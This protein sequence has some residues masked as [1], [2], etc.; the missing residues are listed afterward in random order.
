M[1]MGRKEDIFKKSNKLLKTSPEMKEKKKVKNE[2]EES[3]ADLLRKI[4]NKMIIMK[5]ELR[6]RR[7]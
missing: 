5:G 7:K 2:E 3:L 4:K 1:I 6:E